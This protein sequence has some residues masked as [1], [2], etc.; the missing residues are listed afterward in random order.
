MSNPMGTEFLSIPLRNFSVAQMQSAENFIARR[1]LTKIPVAQQS[2]PYYVYPQSDW[3]RVE[4]KP[5]GRGSESA[6]GGWHLSEDNYN[7]KVYAVHKDNDAQDYANANAAQILNL[8]QD[9]TSYVT[10][11]LQML[12]D[13]LFRDTFMPDN[14]GVWTTEYEGTS[15]VPTTGQFLQWDDPDSKPIDDIA[16]AVLAMAVKNGGRRARNL[17][18]PPNVYQALTRN[19]QIIEL[20]QF[21]QGGVVTDAM[22]T[23]ALGVDRIDVAWGITNS[24]KEG[25]ADDIDFIF[26]N[27]VLLAYFAPGGGPKVNT[28]GAMFTWTEMDGGSSIGTRVDRIPA[29]LIHSV[30]IEGMA[31]FDMKVVNPA[32][33]TLFM[34]AIRS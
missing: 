12:E 8:D 25:L 27:N 24:G 5:L 18:M 1:I 28:A 9:A 4:A 10:E 30:R 33:G 6:G 21:S 29:P 7:A 2:A 3:L 23:Q 32:A 11:Q 19:P 15:A 22:L 34:N 14:G 17:I 31:A 20:Y 16:R 26:G 13:I